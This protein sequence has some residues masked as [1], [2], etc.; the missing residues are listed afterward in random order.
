M[1][2]GEGTTKYAEDPKRAARLLF[3][4]TIIIKAIERRL[5]LMKA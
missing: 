4:M 3:V 2:G 5:I 1:D